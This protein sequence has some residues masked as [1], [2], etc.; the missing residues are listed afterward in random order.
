MTRLVTALAIALLAIPGTVLAQDVVKAPTADKVLG[1]VK[2][3]DGWTPKLTLGATGAWNDSRHVVGAV[4]GATVV[5]GLILD[6]SATYHSGPVIWETTLKMTESQTRTPSIPEFLK[7]ADII[8][9]A[10]T[11]GYKVFEWFGPFVRVAANTSAFQ[12]YSYRVQDTTVSYEDPKGV[13]LPTTG[14]TSAGSRTKLTSAFEPLL[15]SEAAGVFANPYADKAFTL[16]LKAGA[17]AQEIIVRDGYIID[18]DGGNALLLRELQNSNEAG[19]VLEAEAEGAIAENIGWKAKAGFFYPLYS[20]VST[21]GITGLEKMSVDLSGK[22][23]VRLSKYLTLDYTL[24]AKHLPLITQKTWQVQ[25][26]VL[27]TAAVNLL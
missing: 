17:G 25:N 3:G 22:L 12:G 10:S 26:G 18:K 19:A 27:L 8:D 20:S 6:G 14:T 5:L 1:E 16:K 21:P 15:L 2:A 7:S 4:D 11:Y 13:A 24:M 23:S 9:L